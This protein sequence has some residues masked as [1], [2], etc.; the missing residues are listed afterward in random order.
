M[1]GTYKDFLDAKNNKNTAN[2]IKKPTVPTNIDRSINVKMVQDS[3][4]NMYLAQESK[5]PDIV[6]HNYSKQNNKQ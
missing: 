3:K 1:N 4:A 6:M 2:N 5:Q